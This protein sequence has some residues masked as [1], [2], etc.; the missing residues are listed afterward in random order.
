MP[1]TY[2]YM[3]ICIKPMFGSWKIGGKMQGKENRA[4]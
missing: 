2:L 3:I 1:T 4:E